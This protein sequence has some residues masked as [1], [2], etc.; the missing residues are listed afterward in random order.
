MDDLETI[1]N[2]SPACDTLLDTSLLDKKL[3][4]I[5]TEIHNN[6]GPTEVSNCNINRLYNRRQ[7]NV[8]HMWSS[9]SLESTLSD[10][11]FI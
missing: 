3:P 2:F 9:F 5:I 8:S 4:F 7:T 10:V 6:L 11:G 1:P